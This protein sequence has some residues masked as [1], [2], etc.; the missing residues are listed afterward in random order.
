[1]NAKKGFDYKSYWIGRHRQ[2]NN[3]MASVGVKSFSDE[4]N[5]LSYALVAEQFD[6]SLKTT[7]ITLENQEVL[8]AGAGIG[9]YVSFFFG[10]KARI[11]AVDVSPD[12]IGHLIRRYPGVDARTMSLDELKHHYKKD[13]FYLTACFDVLYHI[14]DPDGWKESIRN[15]AFVTKNYLV[16]H[17]RFPVYKSIFSARHVRCRTRKEV[18]TEM[19]ENN[20]FEIAQI[21]TGVIRRFPFFWLFNISPGFFYNLDKSLIDCEFSNRIAGSFIK[22]FEKS[23]TAS[24]GGKSEA[25]IHGVAVS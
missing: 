4:A 2:F 1:M 18:A 15:L 9:E 11:S 8:D 13:Q 20:F 24:L 7:G 23:G 10:K 12:A 19:K 22:I 17:E 25:V 21:P 5:K 3:S 14:T 6:K 16:L